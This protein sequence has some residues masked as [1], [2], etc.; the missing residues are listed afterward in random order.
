MVRLV[1]APGG[2]GKTRLALRLMD[3]LGRGWQWVP[4]RPGC[5]GQAAEEATADGAPGRLL[6]VV[7]YADARVPGGL[8]ELLV[9]ASRRRGDRV[10]VLLLAR[11]AGSWWTSLSASVHE[12]AALLDALTGDRRNVVALRARIDA[13]APGEV[14]AQAAEVFARRLRRPVPAELERRAY[15]EDAPVLRLHASA[16]VAV[17]GGPADG[18]G[19]GDVI[20]EVL[21]HERRYWRAK[22]NR[23]RVELPADE[24]EADALLAR[25]VGVAA[26]FGAE[27]ERGVTELVR[28]ALPSLPSGEVTSAQVPVRL[29][30]WVRWLSGLYPVDDNPVPAGRLGTLQPDLLAEHLAVGVLGGC[31]AEERGELFRGLVVGQAVQALTVLGRAALDHASVEHADLDGF[32]GEALAA[33]IPTM[34]EAVIQVAVQFPGRFASRMATVLAE[35]PPQELRLLRSLVHRV[36][37]PSLELNRLAV[38]LTTAI[39]DNDM[40][41]PTADRARWRT[42]H[43]SRL[44]E[45]GRRAEA[46]NASTEAVDLRRELV[47][48]NRDVH[49]PDL[50]MSVHNH[51]TRLAEAGRWAEALTTSDE[52][53][54]LCREL[55]ALNRDAHLPG[56]A[57][58]VNNHAIRLAE[59]GRRAEALNASTEAVDLYR[60]LVALNRDAYLPD[61]AMSVDNHA[62][63]LAEAGRRAEAMTTSTEAVDLY[64]ELVALNRDAHLPDLAMSVHNHANQLA[65]A[66]RRVEALNASTEAV[67]IRRELVA[68]NRDAYLPNLAMSVDNHAN[69]LAEAGRRAEALNASTEAVDL[70]R[71]LVALNRDAHLPNLAISV[72]NHAVW[73]AEAGR[74]VEALNAS[75]EAID[76]YRELVALNR[77][78]HLPDLA[79]SV[80][81]HANQ[82]AEAGRRVEALNASTEAVDIRRELVALN[83]DAHLPDLAGSVNNHAIQLA[84]AGRRVEA[85]NASAEAVDIR[86]ELVALNRDAYLPNLARSL[87]GMGWVTIVLEAWEHA[88][89]AVEA[90]TEAVRIYTELSATEPDAFV[91]LRDA[92]AKTLDQLNEK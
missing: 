31:T 70:Y 22:A 87:C 63:R 49:L 60:E 61:L 55:V 44:A 75:T 77:D 50:A 86:R 14:V 18:Y 36:P 88:P 11:T 5:E 17:L 38:A 91:P 4:V 76:L 33:D 78:A 35:Q 69:R 16:L 45:A 46:L 79:M 54:K 65:E 41:E 66:G 81:N 37:Y 20:A 52:A 34:T 73:L 43:A 13:R 1:F 85:L 56:L 48:L 9:A 42:L 59:A 21:G 58:S 7:D 40:A 10:R 12:H 3:E 82:L 90:V 67:D 53:V 24:V 39:T 92:A 26:L 19:R 2:Y 47:A 57:G 84:E 71:E 15:P 32:I 25:V 68:L 80:H 8:A 29:V 51:A 72:N 74:R 28:R 64:R 27:D 62:V 83:R 89:R 6:L 23:Q 30:E